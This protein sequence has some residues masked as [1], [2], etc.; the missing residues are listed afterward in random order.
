M[1][2][3]RGVMLAAAL[4]FLW[5][6]GVAFFTALHP[7]GITTDGK[8]AETDGSNLANNPVD[9]LKFLLTKGGQGAQ[10]ADESSTSA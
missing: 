5:I 10:P 2:D 1:D 9:V 3:N 4:L 7:G 8:K 6:A